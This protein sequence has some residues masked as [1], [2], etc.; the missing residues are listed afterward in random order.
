MSAIHETDLES[1]GFSI[2]PNPTNG[3]FTLELT[4]IYGTVEMKIINLTGQVVYSD[5]FMVKERLS[6]NQYN[7]SS[8][9]KVFILSMLR[10]RKKY[11]LRK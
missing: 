4:D 1:D 2:Y 9:R 7:L 8:V 5:E 11:Y 6:T 3:S 10:L